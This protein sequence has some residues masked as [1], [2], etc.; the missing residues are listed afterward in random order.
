[1]WRKK[2]TRNFGA[3]WEKHMVFPLPFWWIGIGGFSKGGG[4]HS[5]LPRAFL[6]GF[7]SPLRK[8]APT[9]P[10]PSNHSKHAKVQV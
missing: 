3:L 8:D 1:M 6:L 9:F 5:F 4:L 2:T 10:S 7:S